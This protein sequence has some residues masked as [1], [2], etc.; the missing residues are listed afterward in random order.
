MN[1]STH[2]RQGY[3][4]FL[5]SA[6]LVLISSVSVFAQN[7]KPYKINFSQFDKV[8]DEKTMSFD[9]STGIVT[10]NHNNS[11]QVSIGVW[12]DKD[13]SNY[14]IIRIKYQA[15]GDYGFHLNT[16]YE[17]DPTSDWWGDSTYCPSYLTEM[18]IPIKKGVTKLKILQICSVNHIWA[19]KFRID[20]ITLEYVN[21]PQKI[22]IAAY[23]GAPLID[24]ATSGKFNDSI[25][26]WDFVNGL[27][28][29]FQYG[30]LH[31]VSAWQDFGLDCYH[32]SGDIKPKK[33]IIQ[34]IRNKGFRTLR[35]QI[36]SY[37][38]LLDDDYT[39]DP[40]FMKTVKEVV[41]W[42]IEE[43]MYVIICGPV[44]EMLQDE[45]Y[46]KKAA[47]SVHF[48]GYS[49]SEKEKKESMRFLKAIWLQ[50]AKAFN[51]SYD[52]HLIFETLNEPI[53]CF[54]EHA[55]FPQSGCAVC[56]KDYAI[57]KEYNQLIV[58]TI[59]STGGNNAK[60][61]IMVEGYSGGNL[62]YIT[63]ANKNT[64]TL[65]KDKAKD[66]LIPTFHY[67][68]MGCGKPYSKKVYSEYIKKATQ[69]MFAS[70]DKLYFSKHIPVYMSEGLHDRSIP[71]LERINCLKDFM[72]EAKK[73]GRSC[74][75]T[76]INDADY[77]CQWSAFGTLSYQ[78]LKWYDD[79]YVYT[80]IYASEEKEYPLSENFINK[81]T[82]KIE[83]IVGKN[84]LTEPVAMKQWGDSFS[85]SSGT[86]IRSTPAK[87]KFVCEIETTGP[88]PELEFAYLD[89]TGKWCNGS[90]TAYLRNLKV[91]GGTVEGNIKVKSKTIEITIDEKL[92]VEL[93]NTDEIVFQGQNIILKSVKV[94]E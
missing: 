50:Y 3:R 57:L 51:N 47:E 58:D 22:D 5:I 43:D 1:N 49:V 72:A 36:G 4:R 19:Y 11:D 88:N 86:L 94:M 76:M 90:N 32:W 61:F 25:S 18:V 23:D 31:A 79:E 74:N 7:V 84:L 12:V 37:A 78:D 33:E 27:G 34:T 2:R 21:N 30:A 17:N 39:I 20:E 64:F 54:H 40:R 16:E 15:L 44:A 68:P 80:L 69:E 89:S 55:W 9:K 85:F 65:P 82:L 52:E 59:R 35:L 28:A 77:A 66:K 6:L 38:H 73:P 14:N 10:V 75:V 71:I 91:K 92:A 93:E 42:A 13:I 63:I 26:A 56:K 70:F 48:A 45:T 87:Y 62:N 67:Y 29:G 60:R 8:N 53:D 41:D 46:R 81:N 24:T 83:S